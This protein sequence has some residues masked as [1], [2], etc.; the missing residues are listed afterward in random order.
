M[1]TGDRHGSE[2]REARRIPFWGIVASI[3]A[4]LSTAAHC[5]VLFL[6]D[7]RMTPIAIWAGMVVLCQVSVVAAGVVISVKPDGAPPR[8]D[9]VALC[10]I[11][12]LACGAY[13]VITFSL[14]PGVWTACALCVGARL[15]RGQDRSESQASDSLSRFAWLCILFAGTASWIYV[16]VILLS[17]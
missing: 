8:H 17:Q 5:V 12:T 13:S 1:S 9:I 10:Y 16:F 14:V 6:G 3:V 11:A 4:T 7:V 2:H 15:G